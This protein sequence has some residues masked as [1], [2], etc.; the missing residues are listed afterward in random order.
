M[1]PS[2][3]N[4]EK[5][6]E[7]AGQLNPGP[8]TEHSINVGR[9]SK[10]IAEKCNGMDEEKAYI[11]GVLHDIGRRVGVVAKRHIIDGY[12]YAI[13]KGWDEVARICLTHSFPLQDINTDIGKND[14]TIEENN[15]VDN[16]LKTISYND[17]DKLL[18]LC[19]ALADSQGFCMLEKRFI[20]TTRRYGAFPFTVDRWNATFDIKEYFEKQM[21]CSIY[22]VLPNVKETTFIEAPLWKP[23]VK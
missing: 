12:N 5:E 23:P 9:A 11:I 20:N 1:L 2:K 14:L 15:F 22:D 10:L 21:G 18:I 6:L 19:D 13:E 8:W 7:L 17:Y 4:A 16:Y 3:E